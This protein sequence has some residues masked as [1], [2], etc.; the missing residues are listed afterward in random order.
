[1]PFGQVDDRIGV[2]LHRCYVDE[3][4]GQSCACKIMDVGSEVRLVQFCRTLKR[5]DAGMARF[6]GKAQHPEDRS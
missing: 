1:M 3:E 4:F 6:I 5:H 2:R